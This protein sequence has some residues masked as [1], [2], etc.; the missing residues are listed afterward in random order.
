M[1]LPAAAGKLL[2]KGEGPEAKAE[3]LKTEKLKR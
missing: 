3:M 2:A 1:G